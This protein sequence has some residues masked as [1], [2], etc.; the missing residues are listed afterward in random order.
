M[1]DIDSTEA[2]NKNGSN[3][4]RNF[5]GCGFSSQLGSGQVKAAM[6]FAHEEPLV[7][8][9]VSTMVVGCARVSA[10]TSLHLCISLPCVLPT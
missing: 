2:T 6:R 8:H 5:S 1:V 3:L 10:D 7:E 4:D 9:D